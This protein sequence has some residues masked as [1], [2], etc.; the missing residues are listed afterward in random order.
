MRTRPSTDFIYSSSINSP[1]FNSL[2]RRLPRP[3]PITGDSDSNQARQFGIVIDAGSSGS[4]VQIFSWRSH[5]LEVQLRKSASQPLNVLPRVETGGGDGPLWYHKVEPGISSFGSHPHDVGDYLKPLLDH[6]LT[7][8]PASSVSTTSF[9]LLATAGMRLVPALQ[10]QA[11]LQNACEYVMS[12]YRFVIR[13]C[14][15]DVRVITGEEEGEFG[16]IAVNYLMDGFD[17]HDGKQKAST[18]GFLD[19]GGAS[20]QI[21]FEPTHNER[22]AHPEALSKLRLRLLNG[23]DVIHSVF[24]TTWLGYGT[25]QARERYSQQL[26]NQHGLGNQTIQ[27]TSPSTNK[28]IKIPDPC[29]PSSLKIPSSIGSHQFEGTGD[30]KSCIKNLS[31]LLNKDAPCAEAPCLFDGKHVPP[32]DFSVNHFIGISEYWYSTQEVWS[33]G[34]VYDFVEFEKHAIDYCKRDWDEIV[35]DHKSGTRWPTTVE[36][37]RLQS[38]CFK[39]AWI[40]NILHEGIGIPRIIDQ[41][42]SGDHAGHASDRVEKAA[43]KNLNSKPPSFQSVNDVGDV[44]VSWTLG[45]MV[46]EVSQSAPTPLRS[47]PLKPSASV[48]GPYVEGA[49]GVHSA[50]T[51]GM[52]SRLSHAVSLVDPMALV[53]AGVI[54]ICLWFFCLSSR[55]S[56][57]RRCWRRNGHPGGYMLASI[58]EGV[59]RNSLEGIGSTTTSSRPASPR[60]PMWRNSP[61]TVRTQSY[62]NHQ[63][64]GPVSSL[65]PIRLAYKVTSV[66]VNQ[67]RSWLDRPSKSPSAALNY[68][69]NVESGFD[70]Q[71]EGH[72]TIP[73]SSITTSLASVNHANFPGNESSRPGSDDEYPMIGN[74]KFNSE[75]LALATLRPHSTIPDDRPK[76]RLAHSQ[77]FNTLA[78]STNELGLPLSNPR[79]FRRESSFTSESKSCRVSE[80]GIGGGNGIENHRLQPPRMRISSS[81]SERLIE[82][83][84]N[85]SVEWMTTTTGIAISPSPSQVSLNAFFTRKGRHDD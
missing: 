60:P 36:I 23:E 18:F 74:H 68:F 65:S 27:S 2:S 66:I 76:Q 21:A 71:P 75:R 61:S 81:S 10:R 35:R 64:S 5:E 54:G 70:L 46:L 13:D 39:A 83:H 33:L 40:I 15:T 77:S 28:I 45:K 62:R 43:A 41:G 73:P 34:G 31:P 80:D 38:Q 56:Y 12:N 37:S 58:E 63:S 17:A 42:G 24:V 84:Q 69:P 25:N 1:S 85:C 51:S 32:I 44:L 55:A 50:Q 4:R 52:K 53:G 19:M 8:I 78:D 57:N 26:L 30:F 3:P 29:L 11:I 16:W 49:R 22:K 67:A 72:P 82:S 9:Y 14:A 79:I 7:V 48:L 20:T 59:N 6:A 47:I